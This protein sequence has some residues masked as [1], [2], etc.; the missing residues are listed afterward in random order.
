VHN[1]AVEKTK[2]LPGTGFKL[3]DLRNGKAYEKRHTGKH[4]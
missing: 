4:C 2:V 3:Q 1:A